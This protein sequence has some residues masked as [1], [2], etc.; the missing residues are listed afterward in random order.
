MQFR[1]NKQQINMKKKM[2]WCKRLQTLRKGKIL[3]Y[4]EWNGSSISYDDID[5]E[6]DTKLIKAKK[7]PYKRHKGVSLKLIEKTYEEQTRF[8]DDQ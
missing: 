8:H 7:N 2:M 4:L 6:T 5:D 1:K 3:Y